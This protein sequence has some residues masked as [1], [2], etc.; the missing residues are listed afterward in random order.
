M[1]ELRT[2]HGLSFCEWTKHVI[3][4]Q[5][6]RL[7]QYTVVSRLR[8]GALSSVSLCGVLPRLLRC[9]AARSLYQHRAAKRARGAPRTALTPDVSREPSP[10]SHKVPRWRVQGCKSEKRLAEFS[11]DAYE[12]T[13]SSLDH[14]SQKM[15]D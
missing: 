9:G 11:N 5:E 13:R 14:S 4:H 7:S 12:F 10:R 2:H 6:R 3:S 15:R 1:D 8:Y